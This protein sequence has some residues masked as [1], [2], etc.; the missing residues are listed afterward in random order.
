MFQRKQKGFLAWWVYDV[1]LWTG[2]A[3]VCAFL[4]SF[5][6]NLDLSRSR[7]LLIRLPS[8]MMSLHPA[9][10]VAAESESHF[11]LVCYGWWLHD[12]SMMLQFG[13]PFISLNFYYLY[14]F[15][16]DFYV[17]ITYFILKNSIINFVKKIIFKI[18]ITLFHIQLELH[19]S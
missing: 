7:L 2:L 13:L 15:V 1:L 17:F 8:H 4:I 11:H 14:F 6:F 18:K 10:F 19:R 16:F 5:L 3:L 9:S 12:E